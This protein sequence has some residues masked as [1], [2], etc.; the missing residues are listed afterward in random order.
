M[1][2]EVVLTCA[3]VNLSVTLDRVPV[4]KWPSGGNAWQSVSYDSVT[5]ETLSVAEIELLAAAVVGLFVVAFI[6]KFLIR[7]L[8]TPPGRS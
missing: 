7:M 3:D 1:S 2:N 6:G 4:C 8:T 5:L